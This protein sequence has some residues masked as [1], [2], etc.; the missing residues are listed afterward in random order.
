MRT[1]LAQTNYV[2]G[3]V[4]PRVLGRFDA[5]KPIFKNGA[6]IIEN[7]LLFQAGSVMYR[8]GTRFVAEVKN[9]ANQ[10]RLERFRY[11]ITQEYILEI[12]N[13]Y[14]RFF[15]NSGQVLSAGII[16][17]IVT[18]FAQAD[19]FQLQMAN[20]ADVMYIAHKNYP[21]QKLVRT[22]ANS[23]TISDAPFIRG[24]FIDKNITATTITPSADIGA[25]ITLTASTAIFQAGH[26]GSLWRV[27]SGVVKITGF[28]ST[29]ILVGDV[30]A[31]PDGTAGNLGTGPGAT[32]DWAEGAFS[33]VRGYPAAVTFHEQRLTLGGTIAEPQKIWSSSIGAYDNF[34]AGT[35]T[36]SDSF[37]FEISSNL[38]NDIRWLTTV[39][40]LKIGTSGGTITA[41]NVTGQSISASNP[42]VIIVDSDYSVMVAEV[43]SLSGNLF[44]VQS[45][46]FILR[47][48]HYD[49]LTNR[50]KSDDMCLLA[51]H[52]LRDGLGAV[53]IAR[54]QSPNDRIWVVR[55]DG[56]I[57]IFTRNADQ[58]VLGW[59]RFV[60]GN[61]G[62]GP[63][64]FESMAILPMDGQ[65]DQIWTACKRVVNGAI[66]RYVEYFT[67]ELFENSWEPIRLDAS[68]TYDTPVTISAMTNANPCV[69]TAT[70]HGFSNGDQVKINK[71]IAK[72]TDATTGVITY[73]D[74]ELNTRSFIVANKTADTFQITDLSGTPIN[75][76]SLGKYIS[77]GQV[78]KMNTVFSGL[79]HL[80]GETIS[81]QTDGGLPAGTQTFTVS[82]GSIT[83][84]SPAAVVHAGLPYTGTLR[85]LP[86]GEGTQ[87][88]TSQTKERKV[89]EAT[90]RVNKSIGG[91]F[92]DSLTN[93]F[94]II[95]E[96]TSA[97]P[98]YTGD[99]ELSFE[100][101]YSKYWSPFFVCD[102]PLPF[103][104][105]AS[106]FT[107][108]IQEK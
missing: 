21:M 5:D 22:S 66:K 80:E 100:S 98:L 87:G 34:N 50:D 69:I 45:N 47:Q 31:E 20:K 13:L 91:K 78:R 81:V 35:A 86:M 12:G 58:Q 7:W 96:T 95:F 71:I 65:D 27:K 38:V 84:T 92:G 9:S 26:V 19:I 90:V 39:E 3:E 77:S 67:N 55:S 49:Y 79:S 2:L 105:L 93:L 56:Q 32:A 64:S 4:S 83:L 99:Q 40:D 18:K 102:Q 101:F 107:S 10:V 106:V 72:L 29:T 97:S 60:G 37:T 76:T 51:D 1:V 88:G 6:A 48:A 17:E 33:A 36:D 8:P 85:M 75:S 94:P 89:Y 43:E 61:T 42:P 28:T 25:A 14:M 74:S 68:L 62:S 63:G 104:L 73:G 53:Q 57:A 103:M 70:A 82:G 46:K 44:Y 15:S 23:F 11:S 24:P 54:Q 41:R 30:Q 108:D 16:V 59:C 52:I